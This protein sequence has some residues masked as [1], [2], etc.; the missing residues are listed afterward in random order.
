MPNRLIC[1]PRADEGITVARYEIDDHF[2][3]APG[4]PDTGTID[5]WCPLIQDTPYQRVLSVAV[6]A[7]VRW[8]VGHDGDHGNLILHA[9]FTSDEAASSFRIRYGVERRRLPHMLDPACVQPLA[10][11]SLFERALWAEEF[12]DISDAT[13]RL[14]WEVVGQ[15]R[16]MLAQAH[17]I[18]DYV[19]EHMT[20][21]AAEQSWKGS[22]E[23]ALTCSVGNCNDIHALFI[24]L[25]RSVGIPARLVLGQALE[26]PPPGQE[27]CDLCGYHCW[28][29]FFVAGLGWI[30][31]DASCACKYAKGH[32]FGDLEMN[33]IAWSVGRDVLLMPPPRGGRVLFFAGPY[34]EVN[35]RARPVVRAIRFAEE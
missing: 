8:T 19:S 21:N 3:L 14:D 31:A 7:P 1:G 20:Y 10:T 25:C 18:Y 13:R 15:E 16:N 9:R 30:P 35:G 26:P 22:T 17:R 24:S 5:V 6:E 28:A 12:V 2:T 33:H 32:L 29:E 11:P 4:R 34:A 23:H 27:A